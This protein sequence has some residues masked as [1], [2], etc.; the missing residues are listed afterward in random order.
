MP[1]ADLPIYRAAFFEKFLAELPGRPDLASLEAAQ[2]PAQPLSLLGDYV[3]Y[4]GPA[5]EALPGASITP[6][7]SIRAELA[8]AVRTFLLLW[9]VERFDVATDPAATI[10]RIL[11]DF[12]A[13]TADGSG[14]S[15]AVTSELAREW[16]R[17]LTSDAVRTALARDLA[18]VTSV[19][20]GLP[21]SDLDELRS[22][23][24][25]FG[26]YRRDGSYYAKGTPAADG[27]PAGV[28]SAYFA[29]DTG[30]LA[31]LQ[32]ERDHFYCYALVSERLWNP[33][34]DAS[35]QRQ[36]VYRIDHQAD[37]PDQ[38]RLAL[39]HSVAA[40][41]ASAASR[42]VFFRADAGL[43]LSVPAPAQVALAASTAALAEQLSDSA[44]IAA[45]LDAPD[46]PVVGKPDEPYV[47]LIG[48][49][50]AGFPTS[51]LPSGVIEDGNGAV[52]TFR[53]PPE[54]LLALAQRDDVE[55]LVASAPVWLSMQQA[56]Q[57]I[58]LAGRVL[59]AGVTAANTGQGV[60]IGLVDSGIDGGHPAFLGRSD[61][62]TKT[63]IHSVWHLWES[64][65]SSPH[66]RSANK[67]AYR[68][69]N[70]GKEYIGHDEVKNTNDF[71]GSKHGHGT[72]VAGIA[73][74]K[75][76]GTWPG[77]IAPAATLVVAGIG[78]AGGYVNDVVAGVKYCFQKAT[79]LGLP[80]VVN[81]SLG[82]ERHSHDG[83]DPLSIALTQLVSENT[84]PAVA[85]SLASAMPS[86]LPGRIICAAAGNLRGRP[87]HWQTTIA[88][89][90]RGAVL[91]Q[92]F[93]RGA[94]SDAVEDGVTFWAYNQDATTVRLRISARHSSQAVLATADVPAL[95][96]NR[97]MPTNFAGGLTVRIHN[98]PEAPNNRHYNPEVYWTRPK[99]ATPVA[100]APWIIRFRND[101]RSPCVIHGF[102]AFREHAGGFVFDPARTQPLIGVT[103]GAAEL[104]AFESHKIS[105]PGSAPGVICVAAYTSRAPAGSAD[106][107]DELASFTSPGPLRAAAPG[108]RGIDCALPGHTISSAASWTPINATRGVTDKSG[109][110]MATP[111]M[112]GLVAGLLQQDRTLSTGQIVRRIEAATTRRA[113]DSV[114]DWGLGRLDAA[115]FRA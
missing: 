40:T 29:S 70:F 114:E 100:T 21:T 85:G 5:V 43:G 78:S 106:A 6:R 48:A 41:A 35:R 91:Y 97:G 18:G 53:C 63:R 67:D 81:I 33:G 107:V 27:F 77:G 115:L 32:L 59:P 52:R 83:S 4:S 66:A 79:E 19:P 87:L 1:H 95:T 110:S 84:V 82:T 24:L 46:V 39:L 10:E 28:A 12:R 96:N 42:F 44:A 71:S 105:T 72:H 62:A 86:Y 37:A 93:G 76:F 3:E 75:A 25:H 54:H 45:A 98:G 108:Q 111:V 80:C 11:A 20:E 89:G 60:L 90:A 61:D 9:I 68:A 49:V 2:P 34:A 58:N 101:G 38:T 31:E 94:L 13:A 14:E 104:R 22:F 50:K 15:D 16:A 17:A 23:L 57:E 69:M 51:P 47:L 8:G 88:P 102:A 92:P 26:S 99:P 109:T 7:F 36:L 30:N 74:G 73:A 55:N 112:T 113:R 65:G 56:M 64:G 103:Y